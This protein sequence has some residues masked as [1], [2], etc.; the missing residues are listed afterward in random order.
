MIKSLIMA[1]TIIV[2][3][4]SNLFAQEISRDYYLGIIED[5]FTGVYL[6]VEYITI[7]EE[8]KNHSL[9]IHHNDDRQYHDILI[10]N[11]NNIYSNSKW[12]DGYAIKADEGNLFQFNRSGNNRIIIDNNGYSYKRIGE[13]SSQAYSLAEIFV[14]KIVFE[15]LLKQNI[16]VSLLENRILIPFLYFFTEEDT[17]SVELDDLHWEK[18]GSILLSGRGNRQFYFTIFM[19]TDGI[20]Y[21]FYEERERERRSP[22]AFKK[23]TPFFQFNLNDDK[24]ILLALAGLNEKVENKLLNYLDGL[25]NYEKRKII[26]AMFALNGYYFITEEWQNYFNQYS[27]YKPNKDI[28]NDRNILIIRQQRLLD[29]L[30]K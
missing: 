17:F 11:K 15:S 5:D 25:T 14:I 23:E 8:T 16:G 1:L 21:I 18:G 29:H 30:N 19:L 24:E 3:G 7:L 9:A 2:I 4:L 22:F 26:N 12:H 10:V 20:D 6:P 13:N 27:W 28:R